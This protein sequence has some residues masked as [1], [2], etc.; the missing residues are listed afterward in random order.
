MWEERIFL[1]F[2]FSD[3]CT[4]RKVEESTRHHGICK[5]KSERSLQI[6]ISLIYKILAKNSFQNLIL[7]Y[8]HS[9][10]IIFL[11][12]PCLKT[13]CICSFTTFSRFP[14]G[15]QLKRDWWINTGRL[16]SRFFSSVGPLTDQGLENWVAA[17]LPKVFKCSIRVALKFYATASKETRKRKYK[18]SRKWHSH[19]PLIKK[20]SVAG[21]R[22]CGRCQYRYGC[23]LRQIVKATVVE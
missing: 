18:N 3:T 16:T 13:F 22:S 1:Q 14:A 8:L 9:Q 4:R 6:K 12:E 5:D 10:Q 19:F 11:T 17:C 2:I 15:P 7:V 20:T 23:Q 21:K